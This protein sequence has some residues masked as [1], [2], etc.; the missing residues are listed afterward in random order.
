MGR[1]AGA[2]VRNEFRIVGFA[3][4]D[5][6]GAAGGDHRQHAAVLQASQQ[7]GAFL[8]DGQ[9]SAPVN[10]EHLGEAEPAQGGSQLAGNGCSDRHAEFFAQG[11][12]HG[13]SGLYDRDVIR[14]RQQIP[15]FLG[16]VLFVQGAG[17]A[18]GNALSAV[19]AG[20]VIQALSPGALD[21][22]LESAVHRADNS[23]CLGIDT[24]GHTA[25]AQDA[26]VVVADDGRAQIVDLI[27]VHLALEGVCILH[28]QVDT[29]LL[30]LALL[31]AGTGE[32][33][34]V[35]VAQQQFQVDLAGIAELGSVGLDVHAVGNGQHT[36]RAEGT[37]TGV[38]HAHAAGADLV[39]VLEIA[40]C[41]DLDPCLLRGFENRRAGGN[42]HIDAVNRQFNEIFHVLFPPVTL[43]S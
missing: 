36:G 35:V 26:L 12:A 14:V 30:Q 27:L 18:G 9:V 41:G 39:D 7:L 19:D 21:L 38:D 37:G 1:L 32:A 28:A 8:H 43:S 42:F 20:H 4:L 11:G 31:V 33:L 15:D 3:E 5:P 40:Q 16:A 2:Q 29:H 17:R 23:D 25:A 22:G 6:A 13:G 24:G 34:L 10:V